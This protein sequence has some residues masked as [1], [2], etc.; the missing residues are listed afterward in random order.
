MGNLHVTTTGVNGTILNIDADNYPLVGYESMQLHFNGQGLFSETVVVSQADSDGGNSV[1]KPLKNPLCPVVFRPHMILF[2]STDT[3]NENDVLRND[4]AQ[5]L[6]SVSLTIK[7][8]RPTIA[9]QVPGKVNTRRF[10]KPNSY[11]HIRN[12][13]LYLFKMQE[14]FVESVE[15]EAAPNREIIT[16]QCVLPLVHDTEQ[17]PTLKVDIAIM[18]GFVVVVIPCQ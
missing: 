3:M 8:S 7:M 6:K 16:L 9:Y 1:G 11:V 18:L 14:W 15:F 2:N 12:S 17:I 5:Q 13:R 4:L 10:I